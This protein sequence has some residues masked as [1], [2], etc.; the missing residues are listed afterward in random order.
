MQQSSS[1]ATAGCVL[2]TQKM[3]IN[4]LLVTSQDIIMWLWIS[5]RVWGSW[6][7]LVAIT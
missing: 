2:T 5:L 7:L 1:S 4:F 3:T 6:G